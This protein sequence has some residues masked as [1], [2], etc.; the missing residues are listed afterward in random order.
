MNNYDTE[1]YQEEVDKNMCAFCEELTEY[2]FCSKDCAK[3]Y[4]ND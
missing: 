3:A 2:K 1:P 4:W